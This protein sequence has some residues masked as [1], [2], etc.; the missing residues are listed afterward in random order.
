MNEQ[1]R[2][3]PV[4]FGYRVRARRKQ[5]RLKQ[6][7]VP[8]GPSST[9]MSQIERG[10]NELSPE[11][12]DKL[13]A[14]LKWD[15]ATVGDVVSGAAGLESL[16]I[17][18][19]GVSRS[20]QGHPPRSMLDRLS[21]E[22][23]EA[24]REF[25]DAVDLLVAAEAKVDKANHRVFTYLALEE[26]MRD[27]VQRREAQLG[28]PL[29]RMELFAIDKMER[30]SDADVATLVASWP[31]NDGHERTRYEIALLVA[32]DGWGIDEAVQ[33]S[34]YLDLRD[35]LARAEKAR[36]DA[37]SS[38]LSVVEGKIDIAALDVDPLVDQE[39]GEST[40]G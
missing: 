10:V 1:A 22:A 11:T 24:Q 40:E 31:L 8:M 39:A 35:A 17:S 9:Y 25:E 15:R 33:G 4:A 38:T 36:G 16:P 32:I 21:A 2:F 14:G 30:P 6:N 28:R 7:A 20:E 5:L 26:K 3:D 27:E 23:E 12:L 37:A 34:R 29:T 19:E 13:A 18:D